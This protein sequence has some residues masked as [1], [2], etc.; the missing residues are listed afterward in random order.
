MTRITPIDHAV[1]AGLGDGQ[2]GLLTAI[3]SRS[4]VTEIDQAQ[5]EKLCVGL[6]FQHVRDGHNFK[7]YDTNGIVLTKYH[8]K[9]GRITIVDPGAL[10]NFAIALAVT[11]YITADTAEKF[12]L[13]KYRDLLEIGKTRTD[14]L[15]G[16]GFVNLTDAEEP[17]PATAVDRHI[18]LPV[19]NEL[20]T[21]DKSCPTIPIGLRL[22]GYD[23]ADLS[24]PEARQQAETGYALALTGLLLLPPMEYENHSGY[25]NSINQLM[26]ELAGILRLGARPVFS[27]TELAIL[28]K[29]LE[30]GIRPDQ[31]NFAQPYR[32]DTTI[33]DIRA[34]A[35]RQITG[36]TADSDVGE[37]F[38]KV[39]H[40]LRKN[41]RA[42]LEAHGLY[43]HQAQRADIAQPAL[44]TAI[45]QA[46][47][48]PLD[49]PK[50]PLIKDVLP[51]ERVLLYDIDIHLAEDPATDP[52]ADLRKP[53]PTQYI[54]LAQTLVP[55]LA[56]P[57]GFFIR[58]SYLENLIKGK[59][60]AIVTAAH[61][62]ALAF[63]PHG[64]ANIYSHKHTQFPL[65]FS[66]EDWA[67]AYRLM[68]FDPHGPDSFAAHAARPFSAP[69]QFNDLCAAAK[70]SGYGVCVSDR[71][72]KFLYLVLKYSVDVCIQTAL[73]PIYRRTYRTVSLAHA[74]ITG[75][76]HNREEIDRANASIS[77]WSLEN[78]VVPKGYAIPRHV[79]Q[80]IFAPAPNKDAVMDLYDC[81][82]QILI[83][84][85][86]RRPQLTAY[87]EHSLASLAVLAKLLQMSLEMRSIAS[88]QAFLE[89]PFAETC[90]LGKIAALANRNGLY[91]T[92]DPQKFTAR[93]TST[94]DSLIRGTRAEHMARVK[95][96]QSSRPSK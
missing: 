76:A 39:K 13:K 15:S 90:D 67:M 75:Q 49:A 1:I 72:M 4:S 58:S 92:P 55:G 68:T 79:L 34:K 41:M 50:M 42:I 10:K 57:P 21:H 40:L 19:L 69:I 17:E 16:L 91:Y 56:I 71:Q 43:Q 38:G 22:R 74:Q 85:Q 73:K 95:R 32:R 86:M 62:I 54:P 5:F 87:S 61:A 20:T 93:Y 77:S 60:N 12:D 26:Q 27:P 36:I 37:A 52:F 88:I 25:W 80:Q 96:M 64:F 35:L 89:E 78:W 94:I 51:K 33:I 9:G 47:T 6:G 30:F 84:Q 29:I 48:P 81:M 65:S 7:V 3:F 82:E 53:F 66:I 44:P 59:D 14:F 23:L 46:A 11:G 45:I 31:K 8:P 70:A 83:P 24:T 28:D 2:R 18:H 63:F